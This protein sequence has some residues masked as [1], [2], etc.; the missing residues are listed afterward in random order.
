MK[1][2]RCRSKSITKYGHSRGKQRYICKK[3]QRTFTEFSYKNYPPTSI[4]PL[5]IAY[6]LHNYKGEPLDLIT[7]ETNNLLQFFKS[8]NVSVGSKDKVSKPTVYKWINHY[9][10]FADINKIQGRYFF[11]ELLHQVFPHKKLP[12]P[13]KQD[14]IETEMEVPFLKGFKDYKEFLEYVNMNKKSFDEL[15]KIDKGLETFYDT[16]NK[17]RTIK[18]EYSKYKWSKAT[19]GSKKKLPPKRKALN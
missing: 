6:I 19:D 10:A 1:C 7:N 3:C 5:F 8:R 12:K 2:P 4:H 15:L 16:I 17:L 11:G 18:H 9:E 13:P 14:V